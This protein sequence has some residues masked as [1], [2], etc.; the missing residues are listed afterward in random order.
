MK[1][2]TLCNNNASLLK[3]KK[4]KKDNDKYLKAPGN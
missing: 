3:G 4:K 2:F 1:I